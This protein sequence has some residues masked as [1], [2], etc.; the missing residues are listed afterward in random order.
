MI[1]PPTVCSRTSR[2][3][4]L[5]STGVLTIHI[6]F[7]PL[8]TTKTLSPHSSPFFSFFTSRRF[9][10][11]SDRPN[12][13][14]LGQRTFR[15]IFNNFYWLTKHPYRYPIYTVS[16]PTHNMDVILLSPV[17][18]TDPTSLTLSSRLVLNMN[19]GTN[20][21]DNLNLRKEPPEIE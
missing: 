4:T 17:S 6:L 2:L 15:I 18:D 7:I 16:S 14:P 11:F 20:K 5:F 9:S 13:P 3:P 19:K 12:P 1:P 8:N 21:E 10:I